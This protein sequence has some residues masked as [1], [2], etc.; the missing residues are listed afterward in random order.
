[1]WLS[2]QP[3]SLSNSKITATSSP[4][5]TPVPSVLPTIT[6]QPTLVT[7]QEPTPLSTANPE[8]DDV[9]G[10]FKHYSPSE[11]VDLYYLAELPNTTLN[12]T[13]VAI[14]GDEAVD[15]HIRDITEGRGY[16]KQRVAS[17][18]LASEGGF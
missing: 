10:V 3:E 6:D 8:D 11:F 15:A 17:G 5:S 14:T 1:M 2:L 4:E 7:T 9:V 18:D 16:Q 13:S 12:D